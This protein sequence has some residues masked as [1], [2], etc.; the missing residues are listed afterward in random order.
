M[1]PQDSPLTITVEE[2]GRRL[3]IGRSLAYELARN[4]KLPTLRLG[5]RLLVSVVALE[6][7][8]AEAGQRQEAK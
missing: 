3:K 1:V 7:M 4:G 5:R 2:A 8:L 6:R